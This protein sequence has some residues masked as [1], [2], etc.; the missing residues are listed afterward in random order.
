[1]GWVVWFVA[2]RRSVT[3]REKIARARVCRR[4]A[5]RLKKLDGV[6]KAAVAAFLDQLDHVE[7]RAAGGAFAQSAHIIGARNKRKAATHRTFIPPARDGAL[8]TSWPRSRPGR[9]ETKGGYNFRIPNTRL[10]VSFALVKVRGGFTAPDVT[11]PAHARTAS[12][13]KRQ[14]VFAPVLGASAGRGAGSTRP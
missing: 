7:T 9:I 5:D 4:G 3:P 2:A 11:L 12:G 10:H 8:I 14:K 6:A 13:A 1:M